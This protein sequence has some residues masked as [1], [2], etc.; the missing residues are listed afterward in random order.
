MGIAVR[1]LGA[2]GA[3]PGLKSGSGC[4]DMAGRLCAIFPVTGDRCPD[5][6]EQ[7][8]V[9]EVLAVDDQALDNRAP[10]FVHG[11]ANE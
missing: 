10:V 11:N 1:A 2:S 7:A 8:L 9:R 5:R 3:K 4:R 6:S